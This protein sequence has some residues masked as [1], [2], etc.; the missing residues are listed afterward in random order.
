M[1]ETMLNF[2]YRIMWTEYSVLD[3]LTKEQ[4]IYLIGVV[5]LNMLVTK[6]WLIPV[7]DSEND[8]YVLDKTYPIGA[9]K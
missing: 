1:N 7:K 8:S 3:T 9:V 2:Y 4:I 5:G 6:G